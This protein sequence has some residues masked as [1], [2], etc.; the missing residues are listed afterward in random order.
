[1]D[2]AIN[3]SFEKASKLFTSAPALITTE[4]NNYLTFV[5]TFY[6]QNPDKQL[7]L[8]MK[9]FFIASWGNGIE[10]YNN[11]RRTGFPSN[12]QPTL[13]PYPGEYYSTMIYPDDSRTNNQNAPAEN[14]RTR[15]TFWDV[16]SPILH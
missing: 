2:L 14:V 8:I 9:E 15:K 7:E 10:A 3:A 13:E 6:D 1:M 5:D 4:V 11:Y 12:M 16:N